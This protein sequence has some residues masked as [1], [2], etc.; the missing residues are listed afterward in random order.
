MPTERSSAGTSGAGGGVTAE[1]LLEQWSWLTHLAHA[2]VRGAGDVDDVVQQTFLQAL[3]SPPRHASNL[4]GW[5]ARVAKNVAGSRVRSDERRT[6]RERV[7]ERPEPPA[8]PDEAV[9]RA[10]LRRRVVDAVLALAE[11]YRAVIVM[12][13]L[14]EMSAEEIARILS[15][16][17][18]TVR[19]R[20][21]RGLDLLRTR[22]VAER[23]EKGR[24]LASALMVFV[25]G[26][27]TA[28]LSAGTKLT[29]VA[30]AI[31]LATATWVWWPNPTATRSPSDGGTP[32]ASAAAAS[33]ET[34]IAARTEPVAAERAEDPARGTPAAAPAPASSLT[35]GGVV[36]DAM[37]APVPGAL[38]FLFESTSTGSSADA[39]FIRMVQSEKRDRRDGPRARAAA[40]DSPRTT[41]ADSD[42]GFEFTCDAKL[43]DG[44]IGAW[45]EGTG[46]GLAF[47]AA[48]LE[49][50]A[51]IDVEVTL[52]ELA[53]LRGRVVDAHGAVVAGA[54]VQGSHRPGGSGTSYLRGDALVAADRSSSNFSLN[55][56]S[57][58]AGEFALSPVLFGKYEICGQDPEGM[59]AHDT[60]ARSEMVRFELTP[61]EPEKFVELK[62]GTAVLQRIAGRFVAPDGGPAHL[63]QLMEPWDRE[64]ERGVDDLLLLGTRRDPGAIGAREW[65]VASYRTL[66]AKFAEDTYDSLLDDAQIRFVALVAG[67]VLIGKAEITDPQHGPDVV[68]DPAALRNVP[69]PRMVRLRITVPAGSVRAPAVRARIVW[70]TLGV[71]EDKAGSGFHIDSTEMG[72]V[73]GQETVTGRF[74]E[75]GTACLANVS[76]PGFA[77]AWSDLVAARSDRDSEIAL[78]LRPAE[79][80][81]RIDVKQA[82]GTPLSGAR[83]HFFESIDGRWRAA[84]VADARTSA[85]GRFESEDFAIGDYLV[86]AR[87]D[88]TAPAHGFVHAVPSPETCQLVCTKGVACR[89]EF[90]RGANPVRA[91]TLRRIVDDRGVPV[92]DEAGLADA[93]EIA[94]HG[95]HFELRLV[96]GHYVVENTSLDGRTHALGFDAAADDLVRVPRPE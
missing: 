78:A 47:L 65:G 76:A 48:S 2:L 22:F 45:R 20:L 36:L 9:A 31:V 18:E 93:R 21:K 13:Y 11:P 77:T 52:R 30:A 43:R 16:P 42:G 38:V 62:L 61:A 25:E 24:T 64:N 33:T 3:E 8:S 66:E 23:D 87:G 35:I 56:V 70:R 51:R 82:D 72:L 68:V 89:F 19:T 39:E 59:L 85:E 34:S 71:D 69:I 81:V 41:T 63:A 94:R 96:P 32:T 28:A 55:V 14:D 46:A 91:L 86:V 37:G 67:S 12:R 1:A 5:L 17:V 83:V 92:F 88:D 79:A 57:D 6:K 80:R 15:A 27:G 95:D 10:E 7:A 90:E 4:R 60:K 54:H 26:A 29:A 75:P 58:E 73:R 49:L 50:G 74:A 40:S 53:Q 44:R 84:A